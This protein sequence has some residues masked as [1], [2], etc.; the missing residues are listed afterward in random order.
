MLDK[1][2]LHM[3][4]TFFHLI[5]SFFYSRDFLEVDTPIRQPV[6]IPERNITPLASE[7][8]FL[9]SSP[10]LC[11]KRL[12]AAGN[13]K[14]FQ[15]CHC[16]R[17]GE[18]GRLHL[19]EFQMLE[20][21]RVGADYRQLM[22]DCEALLRF[23]LENLMEIPGLECKTDKPFFSG[24]SLNEEWERITVADAFARYSPIQLEQA[25]EEGQIRRNPG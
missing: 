16:F 14:I 5:R 2:R 22:F 24:I 3:R 13:S 10:E 23:L 15:I 18:K 20:W 8:D 6:Y 1:K 11:M 12:L 17:K 9:Q 4:A 25:M 7:Q 19:E 21:Y